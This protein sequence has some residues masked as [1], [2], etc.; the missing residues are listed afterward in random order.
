MELKNKIFVI[1]NLIRSE[2]FSTAIV[3]CKK[4]LK[5]YPNNSYIYN[6]CGLALQGEKRF[7]IQLNIFPKPY[8]MNL[9]I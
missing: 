7:S 2:N 3:N 9:K 6:L 8:I 4:L 5:K 1:Q